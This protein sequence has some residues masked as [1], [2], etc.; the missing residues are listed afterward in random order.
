MFSARSFWIS[1]SLILVAIA[2]T[3]SLQVWLNAHYAERD[4]IRQ[5]SARDSAAGVTFQGSTIQDDS[6]VTT[7]TV[8]GPDGK[9]CCM[10]FERNVNIGGRLVWTSCPGDR[11]VEAHQ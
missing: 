11:K 2:T 7:V 4:L 3:A 5:T 9:P 8:T 10:Y 1:L 6:D